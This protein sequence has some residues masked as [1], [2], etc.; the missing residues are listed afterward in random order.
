M[1]ISDWSSDVCSS[2]LFAAIRAKDFIVHHPYESFDVVVQFLREA[3]RDPDVVAIKQTLYRTSKN[4]PI[5]SALIEAADAG[6]SVTAM[7]ELKARFDEEANI[8]WARDLERAGAQVVYGF[9]SLKTHAKVAMVVRREGQSLR[10]YV[11]FGTGNYHPVNARIYT[12]L[13]RS[14]EHTSELQSLMRNT[15]A[16]FC[17]KKKKKQT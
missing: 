3:A 12:D 4:S 2:D 10:T 7:V 6:K 16:V 1:R 8:R 13:S 14:E 11:H 9:L 5:V 17:L 15:Y